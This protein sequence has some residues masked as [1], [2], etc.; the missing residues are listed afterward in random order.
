MTA[1]SATRVLVTGGRRGIGFAFARRLAELGADVRFTTRSLEE[2]ER[3]IAS[4]PASCRSRCAAVAWD[5]N[6]EASTTA[7][8]SLLKAHP[9]S[10][11]VHAAHDFPDHVP[12]VGLKSDVITRD[13]A[14]YVSATHSVFRLAS[15]LMMREGCGRIA[16]LSSLAVEV[17]PPGQAAYVAS[18]LAAEGIARVLASESHARGVGVCIVRAGIVDT[19]NVRARVSVEAREAYGTLSGLGRLLT[20]DEVVDAT[21]PYLDPDA[22]VPNGSIVR[23]GTLPVEGDAT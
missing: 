20:V 12:V 9:P 17:A 18:K 16:L 4:L 15:R 2:G 5:M 14:R 22:P 6:D 13:V 21:L 8:E 10:I 7:L 1:F 3:A 11:V 19:E 23:I